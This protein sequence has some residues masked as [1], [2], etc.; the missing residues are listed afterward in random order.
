LASKN[1]KAESITQSII[2]FIS[3]LKK[4]TIKTITFDRGKEF[5]K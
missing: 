2:K 5:N 1:H 3:K 4:G